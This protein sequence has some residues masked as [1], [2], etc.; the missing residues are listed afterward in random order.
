MLATQRGTPLRHVFIGPTQNQGEREGD[1]QR[2][3]ERRERDGVYEDFHGSRVCP[4]VRV[5][6]W[7]T[8]IFRYDDIA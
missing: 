7:V 6:K 3:K 8:H 2:E 1:R 5:Q 4:E